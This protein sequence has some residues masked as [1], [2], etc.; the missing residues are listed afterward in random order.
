MNFN[1]RLASLFLVLAAL[2]LAGQPPRAFFPWWEGNLVRDIN[3]SEDQRR[4]VR[5]VVREYRGKLIDAHAAVEKAEGEV[6]DFFN[7]E[8]TDARRAGE[9]VEK[10]IAARGELTRAFAQMSLK[11]RAVLT[12]EQW[13]QLKH[14]Q[15]QRRPAPQPAPKP[16]PM[17][18][19]R[20]PAPPQPPQPPRPPAGEV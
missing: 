16:R 10:L 14:R 3:L 20:P 18:P 12:P 1:F 8:Q 4:Q 2:P 9:A 13:R 5:D 19:G 15:A 6:E 17:R 11:L 7:D